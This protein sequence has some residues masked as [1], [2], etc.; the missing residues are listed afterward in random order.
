MNSPV[1]LNGLI[2]DIIIKAH[3]AGG[4]GEPFPFKDSFD[5]ISKAMETPVIKASTGK[6]VEFDE[7]NKS[8]TSDIPLCE[9][10]QSPDKKYGNC[11]ICEIESLER[12]IHVLHPALGGS[13]DIPSS[14]LIQ[15][16]ETQIEE[17]KN[18]PEF[19]WDA[20]NEAAI[21]ALKLAIEIVK[22]H[23]QQDR[24]HDF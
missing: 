15:K 16:L 24:T 17:I 5:K 3:Q 9:K 11:L 21:C 8:A 19:R 7:S 14:T 6:T 18:R 23:H 12:K 4:R 20:P 13:S 2:E 22:T 10:H 1:S